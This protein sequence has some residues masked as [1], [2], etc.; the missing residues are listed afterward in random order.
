V[1][2]KWFD[3]WNSWYDYSKL[4]SKMTIFCFGALHLLNR[5]PSCVKLGKFVRNFKLGL[6]RY[7]G[8]STNNA[9]LFFV[10][11]KSKIFVNF[12]SRE[13]WIHYFINRTPFCCSHKMRRIFLIL[14]GF[15]ADIQRKISDLFV[16]VQK[17][18]V[19]KHFTPI[20][21]LTLPFV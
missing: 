16:G 20:K 10:A 18:N 13:S 6:V 15:G 14:F 1:K 3:D 9:N 11:W 21:N 2:Q 8:M 7:I 19:R 17:W 5:L 12:A 4:V